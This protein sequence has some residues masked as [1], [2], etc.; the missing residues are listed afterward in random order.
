MGKQH[1]Y[2]VFNAYGKLSTT[3]FAPYTV[4]YTR[5]SGAMQVD[6]ESFTAA[7]MVTAPSGA[8]HFKISL[9]GTAVDFEASAYDVDS[10]ESAYFPWDNSSVAGFNLAVALPAAS[11]HPV[12]CI[13]LIEFVQAVNG[14]K[15]PLK[16][17]AF[18]AAA[19]VK[20]DV[21]A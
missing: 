21:P 4:T 12:F 17:G 15:Y 3:L 9:A 13:L 18:N 7:A 10:T 1:C 6:F 11:T 8:T 2:K 20:V 14:V 19:I 5:T 16:N